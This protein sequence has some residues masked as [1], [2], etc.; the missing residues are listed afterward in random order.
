MRV[1]Y[2]LLHVDRMPTRNEELLETM[3]MS[4][5]VLCDSWTI[6]CEANV[7]SERNM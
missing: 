4:V 5:M 6:G 1:C 2:E 7:E 3:W